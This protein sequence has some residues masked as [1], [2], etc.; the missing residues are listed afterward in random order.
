MSQSFHGGTPPPKSTFTPTEVRRSL[1]PS[2]YCPQK[3]ILTLT[4][5]DELVNAL[6]ALCT[7]ESHLETAKINLALK[8]DF[9]MTDAWNVFDYN[10]Y[11]FITDYEL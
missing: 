10:Q 6:K 5:E 8:P 9:N 1:S 7:I 4:A 3:A 11:G 2:R